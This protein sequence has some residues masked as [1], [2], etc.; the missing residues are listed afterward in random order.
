VEPADPFFGRALIWQGNQPKDLN[1]FVD[2]PTVHLTGAF[3][4]NDAGEIVCG[5]VTASGE[6]H[7]CLA[8]PNHGADEEVRVPVIR[9]QANITPTDRARELLRRG[10]GMP[11]P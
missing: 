7:A 10:L 1:D 6:L 5:C 9:R 3:A 4:I 2:G 11:R 8:V